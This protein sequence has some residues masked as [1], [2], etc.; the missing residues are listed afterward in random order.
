MNLEKQMR[1]FAALGDAIRKS[2]ADGS[3]EPVIDEACRA[4]PWFTHEHVTFALQQW[5]NNLTYGGLGDMCSSSIA[6]A[7]RSDGG[8]AKNVAIIM[9][10]NI[11]LVGMHDWMCTLLVGHHAL[12]KLSSNDNVLLPHINKM[13]CEI[14]PEMASFTTFV[15]GTMK[16]FDA[17][18]A[19][20]SDNTNHY[21]DYYFGKYPHLLR[22][23][24][25][26]IA[27][28]SGK[29]SEEELQLLCDDIFL[30]FG[31]GCRNVS[32]LMVPEGYDFDNL[33][34]AAGKYA[35][36]A[37][38]HLYRSSLDYH[39]ALLLLNA[40]PFVDGGFFALQQSD[41]LSTPVSVLHYAAYR[42]I[43]Q[44]NDYITKHHDE[45]QCVVCNKKTVLYGAISYTNKS[46]V[47]P[48]HPDNLLRVVMGTAQQP[49][50]ADFADGENTLSFL[51]DV[52]SC[53]KY[54]TFKPGSRADEK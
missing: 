19:T 16:D 23:S 25:H 47:N 27:V 7:M 10:G 11:P 24:R 1:L 52:F 51:S 50:L 46:Y 32:L 20:G 45:L 26:S 9:A 40:E 48:H 22:H 54:V 29:E 53:A 31:L 6:L 18:I 35:H 2:L 38:N 49:S 30:Y 17:V 42:D 12:V 44:V 21:F 5:G 43:S 37:D 14:D 36:F 41:R 3:L 4:N 33:I 15:N 34:A 39:K 13:L 8:T 28:L